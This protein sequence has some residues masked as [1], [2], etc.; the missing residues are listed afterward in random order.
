MCGPGVLPV[1]NAQTFQG[2][3]TVQQ[4]IACSL[5][6]D[7]PR[8]VPLILD[9]TCTSRFL[10]V[11]AIVETSVFTSGYKHARKRAHARLE[12]ARGHN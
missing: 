4:M 8:S 10:I 2:F 6:G 1:R 12:A 3:G 7:V 5:F 9:L 11:I